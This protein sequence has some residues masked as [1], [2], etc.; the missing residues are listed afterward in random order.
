LR[1]GAA[2]NLPQA[3]PQTQVGALLYPVY[4]R[5]EALTAA[6]RAGD[7]VREYQKIIDVRV[8]VLNCP[9]GPLSAT[10]KLLRRS[11]IAGPSPTRFGTRLRHGRRHP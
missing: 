4:V 11:V 10:S 5:A 9:L 6:H 8:I 3:Q 1:Y 7:A 2:P